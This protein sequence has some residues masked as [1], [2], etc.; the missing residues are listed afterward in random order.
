MTT[1]GYN[2]IATPCVAGV[3]VGGGS[4]RM[5]RP[6]A[7][8]PMPGSRTMVEHAVAV[9]AEV[10]DQI[11]ILGH[12]DILPASLS[13][14]EVLSDARP[15]A[16]PLAGLCSLLEHAGQRWALLLACDMPLIGATVLQPLLAHADESVDA[17][18]FARDAHRDHTCC[19][20]YHPRI[21]STALHELTEGEAR[22]QNVL[23][24]VRTTRLEPTTD[25]ARQLTNVN[26]PEE[27]EEAIGKVRSDG[28]SA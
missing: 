1:I 16:G 2:P 14:C 27:L 10:T 5:G 9:A 18:V 13:E 21:L 23:D 24:Q 12:S 11:V 17:V 6:K 25:E 19:A 28:P 8:L 22:L 4:R 20:L 15:G 7:L 26:T 3:L